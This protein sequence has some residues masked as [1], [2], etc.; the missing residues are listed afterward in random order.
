MQ[1]GAPD[2]LEGTCMHTAV[3]GPGPGQGDG[4]P[5]TGLLFVTLR[6]LGGPLPAPGDLPGAARDTLF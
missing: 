2:G 6:R 1:V 3:V 5:V 4:S